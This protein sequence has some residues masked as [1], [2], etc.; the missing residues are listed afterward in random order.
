MRRCR[1]TSTPSRRC[2]RRLNFDLHTGLPYLSLFAPSYRDYKTLARQILVDSGT[3]AL[4]LVLTRS[5]H[6][7]L[8]Q[9]IV[10]A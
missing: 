3:T 4:E 7:S 8:Y 9:R 2:V 6:I 10:C 5:A 1:G